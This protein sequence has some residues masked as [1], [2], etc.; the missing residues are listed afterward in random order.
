MCATHYAARGPRR[1]LE[2]RHGLAEI[3]ERRAVSF[4]ERRRVVRPQR[5]RES[6]ISSENPVCYGYCFA[7]QRLGFFEAL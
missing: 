4:V 2:G 6:I 5:E 3:V 7:K 1:L